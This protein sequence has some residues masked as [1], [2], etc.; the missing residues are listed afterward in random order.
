M[1]NKKIKNIMVVRNDRFGEFLLNIAAFRALKEDFAGAKITAIVDPCVKDL[2]EFIPYLDEVILWKAKK[3]SLIELFKF[4]K[5]IKSRNFDLAIMLNPSKELNIATFFSGIPIRVGYSHKCS[6][7][8][9]HKLKDAKHLGLKHEVDYN[10]D[11][12]G[13]IQAKTQDTSISLSIDSQILSS[14]FNGAD[15]SQNKDLIA[16]HPFTSD[17]IKQWPQERFYALAKILSEGQNLRVV[18]IGGPHERGR[19]LEL[20]AN[21]G[22]KVLNM[23]GRTNLK[24]LA[25]L[26]KKCKLLVSGDSGPVH[27]ACAVGTKVV[28]IFRNDIAGKGPIRWGPWGKGHLVIQKNRLSDII[29]D[30]VSSSVKSQLNEKNTAN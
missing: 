11:L 21:L 13:L 1:D 16:I 15:F 29:V 2:T 10:L 19:S 26:L 27:L 23:T 30:E 20:F 12:V 24:E 8:L 3:H 7:L 18:I 5:L 28:A 17:P 25:V 4:T 14:L 6:F 22:D 9:T